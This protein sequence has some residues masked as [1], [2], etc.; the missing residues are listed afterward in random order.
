MPFGDPTPESIE[1]ARKKRE[2][3]ARRYQ[4]KR[5]R[6]ARAT[7]Q[8]SSLNGSGEKSGRKPSLTRA[9][10]TPASKEQRE[11]R[12]EVGYCI[13]CGRTKEFDAVPIDPAHLVSRAHGGCDSRF[14]TVPL[15]RFCH[16]RFDG[17]VSRPDLPPFDLL[18]VLVGDWDRW[19]HHVQHA[20]RHELPVPLLERLAGA[21]TQWSDDPRREAA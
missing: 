12:D 4:E 11:A 5:E 17:R 18:R 14:C 19:R 1:R 20:M 15:C 8:R 2:E 16:D 13:A 10:F 21:R 6:E 9:G 3:A 7:G